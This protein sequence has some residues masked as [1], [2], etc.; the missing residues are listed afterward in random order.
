MGNHSNG[1]IAMRRK[2]ALAIVVALSLAGSANATLH[3][4]FYNECRAVQYPGYGYV[5]TCDTLTSTCTECCDVQKGY[6][7]VNGHCN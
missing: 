2:I 4:E 1:G 3:C 5:C 7:C 6:C